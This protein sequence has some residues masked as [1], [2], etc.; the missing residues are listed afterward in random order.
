M[1]G[2]SKSEGNIIKMW[3]RK[4]NEKDKKKFILVSDAVVDK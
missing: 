3:E 2:I 1:K 4:E